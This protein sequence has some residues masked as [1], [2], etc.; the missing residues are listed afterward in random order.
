[1]TESEPA[2]GSRRWLP[3]S[4]TGTALVVGPAA[5]SYRTSSQIRTC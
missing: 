3:W 4:A 2:R 5:V 1:M